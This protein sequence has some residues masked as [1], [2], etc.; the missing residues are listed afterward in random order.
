VEHNA[1]VLDGMLCVD[2]LLRMP[3]RPA[4]AVS[5]DG[6][7]SFL[8]CVIPQEGEEGTEKRRKP[9]PNGSVAARD[10]LLLR[11]GFV[12]V[13]ISYFDWKDLKD[14]AEQDSYIIA[15]FMGALNMLPG[16]GGGEAASGEA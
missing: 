4:V 7:S 6:A 12:P 11:R 14:E 3:G 13:S 10:R 1:P 8:R 9:V 16:G 5:F 2:A 15:R